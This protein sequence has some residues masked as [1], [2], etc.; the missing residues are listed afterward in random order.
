MKSSAFLFFSTISMMLLLLFSSCSI[1]KMAVESV[2][3]MLGSGSGTVFLGEEDPRLVGDALPFALKLYESLLEVTPDN[4]KLLLATGQAFT[5]YAYAYVQLPAEMLPDEEVEEQLS[6]L[7]RAK[8]L[9][10][11]ARRYVLR[12]LDLRHPGFVDSLT[13]EKW[14]GELGFM[15]KEDVPYLYWTAMAWM[16]AL[17]TD[18]FDLELLITMP[19]AVELILRILDLDEGYEEGAVHEFLTS[20]YGSVPREIG[21]SEEKARSHY[22]R[23]LELSN[24][25]RAATHVA[26]AT[27]VSV[28]NQNVDEFKE[29]LQMALEVDADAAPRYRLMNILAQKRAIWLLEHIDNFFL[30]MEE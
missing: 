4:P 13:G 18:F 7:E 8:K 5:L 9:Y 24:G 20:Y 26:L 12:A 23:A 29:L 21:G 15:E 19:R 25:L 27:T 30:L 1:D 11:R 16:G 17:L 14:D 6:E 2:A 10:L 28:K 3:E 22:I